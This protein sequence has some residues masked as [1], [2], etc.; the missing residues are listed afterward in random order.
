LRKIS[1]NDKNEDENAKLIFLKESESIYF[2]E[3][4]IGVRVRKDSQW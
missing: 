4:S 1:G 2:R 3:A